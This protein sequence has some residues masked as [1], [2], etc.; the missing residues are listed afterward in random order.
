VSARP[1]I[2]YR[3]AAHARAGTERVHS[4]VTSDPLEPGEV[5]RLE[6]RF[7][8]VD[9]VDQS[10][11]PPLATARPARYRIRLRH[12][13]ERVEVGAFRRYRPDAPRIGH[14]LT[15]TEGGQTVSWEVVEERLAHDEQGEP[16]LDL[17]AERD[18][19]ELD[20][21]PDHEL[22]H[23]LAR[24]TEELPEAATALLERAEAGNLSLE[25]V[26]LEPGEAPDW[27]EAGRFVDALILEE[28]ND[29][30]LELCGVDPN[31]DPREGWLAT[32]KERL[33][34]DLDSFRADI[35]GEHDQIEEWD[36]LDGRIFAAAGNDD[37]EG[38]PY[39][40]YGWMSRLV[41][42]SVLGAAGFS[43]VRKAELQVLE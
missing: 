16:F 18:Y 10:V 19:A 3:V 37:D 30:L 15:T 38:D 42:A 36:F 17:V 28:I 31:S 12:S 8:L 22:E 32:V 29:D 23:T 41:D 9:S 14:S 7:W 4:Y 27:E 26:A 24:G 1:P 13:D 25:L 33:R 20:G 2:E 40:G 11:S 6:G 5:L 35:E 21:L 39:S 43:R 34:A